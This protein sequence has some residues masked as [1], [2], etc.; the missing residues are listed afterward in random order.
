[1]A[2]RGYDPVKKYNFFLLFFNMSIIFY[3]KLTENILYL[4]LKFAYLI[5]MTKLRHWEVLVGRIILVVNE[6]LAYFK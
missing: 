4:I 1:M 2:V 3:I 5:L 6:P